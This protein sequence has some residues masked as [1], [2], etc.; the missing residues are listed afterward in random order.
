M[1]SFCL[2]LA[3]CLHMPHA[4]LLHNQQHA[5]RPCLCTWPRSAHQHRRP[6]LP[7]ICAAQHNRGGGP[8]QAHDSS[9][10]PAL[11]LLTNSFCLD[12]RCAT[13]RTCTY[14]AAIG[15]GVNN[16]RQS[17]SSERAAAKAAGRHPWGAGP[18]LP[19]QLS[20][21]WW[22]AI[23]APACL[24]SGCRHLGRGAAPCAWAHCRHVPPVQLCH[25][26]STLAEATLQAPPLC[27]RA[28][29]TCIRGRGG[30]C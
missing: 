9:Q 28:Y 30:W 21:W 20:A 12:A 29:S 16:G 27:T 22:S 19:P 5:A 8:E 24:Q 2:C 17:K 10:K 13:R 25:L 6:H 3:C 1:A 18:S 14:S 4:A 11:L 26:R 15:R 7:E 23:G